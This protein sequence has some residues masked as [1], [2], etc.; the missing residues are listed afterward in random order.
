[1][2]RLEESEILPSKLDSAVCVLL[3]Y[4]MCDRVSYDSV[5][6]YWMPE[7]NARMCSSS[8]FV[9]IIGTHSDRP[10]KRA[11]TSEEAEDFASENSAFHME[12]S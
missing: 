5:A 8:T 1:V 9:M 12:V 10:D 3:F 4:N 2:F 6:R 11:V 7:V